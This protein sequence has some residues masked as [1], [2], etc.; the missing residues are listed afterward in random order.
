MV[1]GI[2]KQHGGWIQVESQLGHGTSF[3]LF[4]KVSER[5]IRPATHELPPV[6]LRGNQELIL[7]V[8]DNSLV[9]EALHRFLTRNGYLALEADSGAAALEIWRT[10][11]P[12]IDLLFTDMQMP[13]VISGGDLARRLM[14]EK[15]SLKAILTSGFSEEIN[16]GD[17]DDEDRVQLIRK[18]SPPKTI[19]KA[20]H[21]AL[22]AGQKQQTV[23]PN[24]VTTAA[25]ASIQPN[26]TNSLA[27]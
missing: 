25:T 20:V 23:V 6:Q 5:A 12:R 18:P 1:Y 13:G 17:F 7:V 8:D 10:D 27:Q 15:P 4:L 14:T 2:I 19:L 26:Q 22:G 16:R 21:K 9:R 11:A 24:A 3:H